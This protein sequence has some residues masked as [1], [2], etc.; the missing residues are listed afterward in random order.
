MPDGVSAGEA[1]GMLAGV[2]AALVALG[3]GAQWLISWNDKRVETRSAKLDKWHAELKAREAELD[4]AL[5][6]RVAALEA[7]DR[8]RELDHSTCQQRVDKL[9]FFC[10][11]LV[12]ETQGLKPTSPTIERAKRYL[13]REFPEAY[14]PQPPVPAEMK[15]LL[16]LMDLGKNHETE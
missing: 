8:E 5:A 6:S 16:D 11:M 10:V 15:A 14:G 12:E 3:K 1:G 4:A 7:K 2:I 9:L 13:M